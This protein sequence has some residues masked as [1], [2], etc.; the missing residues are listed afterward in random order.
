M[1]GLKQSWEGLTLLLFLKDVTQF[2]LFLLPHP[3][4]GTVH[5]SFDGV[6][7]WARAWHSINTR[8]NYDTIR[9]RDMLAHRLGQRA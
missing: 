2:L 9:T 7:G 4:W 6:Q 1:W 8:M 3:P 5:F